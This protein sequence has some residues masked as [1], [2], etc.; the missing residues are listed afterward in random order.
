[1]DEGLQSDITLVS[2]SGTK[3]VISDEFIKLCSL[4]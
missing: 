2:K 3:Y 4:A 1:M